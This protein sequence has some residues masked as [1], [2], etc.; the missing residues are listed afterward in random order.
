[1]ARNTKAGLIKAMGDYYTA[2][3]KTGADALF[4]GVA[5]VQSAWKAYSEDQKIKAEKNRLAPTLV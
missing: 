2:E 5:Y 4:K 1:M 3:S